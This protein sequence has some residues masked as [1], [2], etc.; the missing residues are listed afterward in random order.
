MGDTNGVDLPTNH[1]AK[2]CLITVTT[3]L[4]LT[5]NI[6]QYLPFGRDKFPPIPW[7]VLVQLEQ[8]LAEHM[9]VQAFY[10]VKGSPQCISHTSKRF[11]CAGGGL[12]KSIRRFDK[13]GGLRKFTSYCRGVIVNLP[14][15]EGGSTKKFR[16][17]TN[18][19]P[20]PP[21]ILNEHSLKMSYHEMHGGDHVLYTRD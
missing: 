7:P 5:C 18:F 3:R 1:G 15:K 12:R 20:S 19:D 14:L 10:W 16:I 13:E 8:I 9:K 4:S 17:L 6:S 21:P 11:V 2:S